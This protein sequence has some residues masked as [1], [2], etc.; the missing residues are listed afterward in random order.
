MLELLIG[1]PNVRVLSVECLDDVLEIHVEIAE[2][3]RFFKVGGMAGVVKDRPQSRYADYR[4]VVS[5]RCRCGTSTG[6]RARAGICRGPKIVAI[7][8]PV[9][10]SDDVA[11]GGMGHDRRRPPGPAGVASGGRVGVAWNTLMDTVT[12]VGAI[13]IDHAEGT[14]GDGAARC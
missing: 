1:L 6:G 13:M 4:L 8:P 12:A 3:N 5:R 9:F 14:R 11:G 7:S 10:V 2:P